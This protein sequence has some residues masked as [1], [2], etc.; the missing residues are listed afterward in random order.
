LLL[1]A[2]SAVINFF[3]PLQS[4][5][6][7]RAIYLKRKHDL[8]LKNYTLATLVY[9][10]F[11]GGISLLCLLSSWLGWW[12]LIL[13]GLGLVLAGWASKQPRLQGRIQEMRLHE[14]WQLG[15]ATAL[16]IALLCL[17]YYLELINVAPGTSLSQAIVYTGAANLALFVSL[18]PGAIG[19]RESFLLLS[20][21]L[22]HISPSTIVAASVLD[23]AVYILVLLVAAVLIFASHAQ[24]Q[25][26]G[27]DS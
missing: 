7:F 8:K 22:H 23:R 11:F 10:G 4:G 6:A 27:K 19:F 14:W 18:T 20:Q 16:Q 13:V 9:Y 1:T 17:V 3:G 2:Y 25:L 21:Q 5:P 24:R 12:L 15:L 26:T